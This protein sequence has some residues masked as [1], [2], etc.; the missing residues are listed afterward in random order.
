MSK[1]IPHL[2]SNPKT[3]RTLGLVLFG[4]GFVLLL[5]GYEHTAAPWP[6][7]LLHPSL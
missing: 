2:V 4:A 5:Q 6:L 3:A 1:A 7:K